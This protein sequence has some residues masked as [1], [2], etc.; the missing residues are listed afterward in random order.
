M[1]MHMVDSCL[2][3]LRRSQP[4]SEMTL[5]HCPVRSTTQALQTL[6]VRKENLIVGHVFVVLLDFSLYL[7]LTAGRRDVDVQRRI[8]GLKMTN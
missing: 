6:E 5:H 1:D 8:H 2:H 3:Q 4:S 7:A